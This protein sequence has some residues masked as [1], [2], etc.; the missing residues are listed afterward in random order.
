MGKEQQNSKYMA[1]L[2]AANFAEPA[3]AG[4]TAETAVTAAGGV[5]AL[6]Q[7]QNSK[8]MYLACAAR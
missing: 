1:F 6:Q 4:A 8:S 7:Q 2:T 3:I 5:A